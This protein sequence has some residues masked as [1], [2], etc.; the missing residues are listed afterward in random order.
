MNFSLVF[1]STGDS[2]PFQTVNNV[3]AD[4][5]CYYVDYL[6]TYSLNKFDNINSTGKSIDSAISKLH[7]AIEECNEFIYELL[8]RYI[9]TYNFEENLDQRV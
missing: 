8:D 7:S 9:E 2:I 4:V 6:N 5:L 1:D 3:S